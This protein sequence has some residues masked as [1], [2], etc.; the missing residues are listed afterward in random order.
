MHPIQIELNQLV[1]AG[2]PGA[3]VYVEDADGRAQFYT[4]GYADLMSQRRMTPDSLYRIGSTTKVFTAVVALQLVDEGRVA[5]SDALADC[6]PDLPIPKADS[7]T[8]EHLMRMRSGLFDF[9]DDPSLLGNLEAHRTPVSLRHAIH[10]GTKHPAIFPPGSKYSYCNTNF[11]ILELVVE[12]ITGHP[13]AEEFDRRI[14]RPLQLRHTFYPPEEDLSL[15]EPYI[16]GYERGPDGW[17]ECSNVFFGRGDG[18]MLSTAPDLA[19]FFRAL[20]V[21]RT[22]LP[23][24]QLHQM[25]YVVPDDPPAP[26]AY[27][28]GIMAQSLACGLVWGHSGGGFG[29]GNLPYLRL[30]TGRFAVF[31]RNG[32][33]GYRISSDPARSQPPRFSEEFRAEVY[34]QDD[35]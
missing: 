10:L 14:L 34:C 8:I 21:E 26:E 22:L 11:C 19:R 9:E 33:H 7:L 12:R 3:F 17:R 1:G 20:L 23:E 35:G 4:A 18:A 29:Y 6:L 24:R 32:S 25:M 28:L 13:L 15:P 31:M 2:L 16:R 30:E 27:G 5:L